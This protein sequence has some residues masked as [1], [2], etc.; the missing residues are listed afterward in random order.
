MLN[1]KQQAF[2]E[3]IIA[4]SGEIAPQYGIDWRLM[5][6]MAILET[7]WG[8]SELAREAHN[9]F[10]I[11][12]TQSTPLPEVYILR[13]DRWDRPKRFRSFASDEDSCHAF[14][15]L[16]SKSSHYAPARD[17]ALVT[18]VEKMAPVYCPDEGYGANILRLM[19][20]LD[21]GFHPAV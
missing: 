16:L 5:A 12:A 4:M 7:G 15:R 20:S 3:R 19:R 14:G 18:F 17:A 21:E 11:M 2:R 1:E 10:G 13:A 6:A 8:Q 9:L